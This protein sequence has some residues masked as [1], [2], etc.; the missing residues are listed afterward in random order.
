L[1]ELPASGFAGAI[2]T[3]TTPAPGGYCSQQCA[4]QSDCGAGGVCTGGLL[5]GGYCFEPCASDADCRDGYLCEDRS[6]G[7]VG[8]GLL[9]AGAAAAAD[10]GAAAPTTVCA[11]MPVDEGDAG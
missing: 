3:A 10:G 5:G 6:I 7:G 1:N 2:G 8:A 11:P 4:E 9:D